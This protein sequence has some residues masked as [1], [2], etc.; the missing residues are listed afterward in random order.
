MPLPLPVLLPGDVHRRSKSAKVLAKRALRRIDKDALA[1]PINTHTKVYGKAAVKGV[2]ALQKHYGLVMDGIVGPNTWKMLIRHGS[3]IPKRRHKI[4]SRWSWGAQSPKNK[5]LSTSWGSN[6]TFWLHHTVTRAPKSTVEAEKAAMRD[7]QRIAFA[8][9]YSDISYSYVVFQSGNIYAGRGY[10]KIGA[11][12]KGHNV[13]IGVALCGDFSKGKMKPTQA[14]QD[15][16]EWLH[17]N[18]L[19]AGDMEP[20]CASSATE[21]PGENNRQA[22]GLKC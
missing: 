7:L 16:I 2:K 11:H 19:K 6:T 9:G 8:R 4:R 3:L 12:T 18:K 15:A 14:A 5:L 10:E 1:G 20:H 13:D 22:F 17:K 21:C